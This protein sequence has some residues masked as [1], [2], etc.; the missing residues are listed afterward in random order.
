M[1]S[2]P[3]DEIQWKSPEWIQQFGLHTG[4]VLDYFSESPFY[5]RTSNNQVLRMQ[6]QFQQMP[7]NVHPQQYLQTRL[8]EMVGT[9]FV[10]AFVREPD[11]WVVRRQRRLDP[12]NTIT[13]HDYY[14]IGANVYQ[15]P[16]IYDVLA[17]RLLSSVLSMKK[18]VALLNQMS[19][20]S[21]SEGGHTYPSEAAGAASGGAAGG[22]AQL[23]AGS[24]GLVGTPTSLSN[25][26]TVAQT[27]GA[28][29]IGLAGP[30]AETSGGVSTEVLAAAFENLLNSVVAPVAPEKSIYIDDIP[31]YG[32]GSTVE[33][34]GLVVNLDDE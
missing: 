27:T 14:I 29:D 26:G 33:Q 32:K 1:S 4:N 11:F 9:E 34:L 24:A 31:L 22:K 28:T 15:S 19:T 6:F 18:S 17:A 7:P 16:M 13:E 30:M 25:P 21:I 3:L 12:H 5:D 10:V 8:A 23:S 2:E 20:F